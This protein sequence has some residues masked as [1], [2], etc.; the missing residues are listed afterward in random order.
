MQDYTLDVNDILNDQLM[1]MS[2]MLLESKSKLKN[3]SIKSLDDEFQCATKDAIKDDG[4]LFNAINSMGFH[5]KMINEFLSCK[6]LNEK[7][8][9]EIR[10]KQMKNRL[11]VAKITSK[12]ANNSLALN[13]DAGKSML[14]DQ[15]SYEYKN[16]LTK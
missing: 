2:L 11:G 10:P 13:D 5:R 8:I 1:P 12:M 4:S 14:F 9:E 7:I 3:V 6:F 16:W 15:G